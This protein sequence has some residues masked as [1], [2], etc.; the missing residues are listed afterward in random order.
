MVN[1]PHLFLNVAGWIDHQ[2]FFERIPSFLAS[3]LMQSSD[4][5]MRRMAPQMAY[6]FQVPVI[7][8]VSGSTS[9]M[10]IWME[11]WSLAAMMRF[12][13]EHFLGMYISTYSPASFPM[14]SALI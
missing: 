2:K 8:P 9:A 12:D 13:A 4:S 10:F 6:V 1:R 5:P 14:Y 7:L 11:A 3:L